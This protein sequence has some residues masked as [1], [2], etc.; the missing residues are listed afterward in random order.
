MCEAEDTGVEREIISMET[1]FRNDPFTMIYK[2]FKRLYPN[3]PCEIWWGVPS[4]EEGDKG[5]YGATNFPDDGSIP[6]V[7]I[8]PDYPVQQQTEVLAH[9]LAHVA[10]GVE[11]EHD[12][13]WETAFDAIYEEYEK[14]VKEIFPPTNTE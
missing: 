1:P 3:K 10:V 13:V 2:A 11:H 7:F 9:E 14:V 6:Q 12:K 8:Y 4:D 5:A